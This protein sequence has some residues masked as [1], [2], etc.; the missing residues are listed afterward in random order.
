MIIA[1]LS[2]MHVGSQFQPD[3]FDVLLEEINSIKPDAV[4]ITGDL[5]NQG[6]VKEFE[7]CKRLISRFKTKKLITM[8]GN[9]DYRNTGYLLFKKYF[10]FDHVNEIGK[11]VVI[12]T[13]G[14]SRPDRN[15]GEIGY[16]QA[17]WLEKTMKKYKNRIK[18]VAMHHHLVGIPNTGSDR[19]T[20]TDAGDALRTI[21]DTDVN[22]VLCGHK[23]RPW[24]WQFGGLSIINAGTATSER[25]RG[26]F[27]N[28]SI[29]TEAMFIISSRARLRSSAVSRLNLDILSSMPSFS[30]S[31]SPHSFDTSSLTIPTSVVRGMAS[32]NFSRSSE[33]SWKSFC[34]L[35]TWNFI[36]GSAFFFKERICAAAIP[37]DMM[38]AIITAM[39]SIIVLS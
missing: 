36:F 18:I 9:H 5:T 12:V 34:S 11:D 19:A 27:A 16:R 24:L 39:P 32:L 20:V 2:D 28:F 30:A 35:S 33:T 8:S 1:H 10:P 37:A 15:D 7:E 23:H 21:L 26:L 25:V 4:V 14:T 3:V 6:L 22:A 13:V 31:K 29:S 38:T 17:L